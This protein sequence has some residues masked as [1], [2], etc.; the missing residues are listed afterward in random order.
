MNKKL[1]VDVLA[2][3][4]GL[5]KQLVVKTIN[6][7]IDTIKEEIALNNKVSM[8][9]FGVFY[10]VYLGERPVRNPQT[11]EALTLT[12]RNSFKF[13]PGNDVLQSLNQT[14]EKTDYSV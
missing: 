4:T 6:A 1:L 11:G 14:D 12:P 3:K 9:G 13:K 10:P 8:R 7:F 5:Q 2:E